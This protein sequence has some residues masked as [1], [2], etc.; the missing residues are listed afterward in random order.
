MGL[1]HWGLLRQK[2]TNKQIDYLQGKDYYKWKDVFVE[3]E[4]IQKSTRDQ[5]RFLSHK[6][7]KLVKI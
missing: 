5:K 3:T 7:Q 6:N 4:D 2:Q 1:A